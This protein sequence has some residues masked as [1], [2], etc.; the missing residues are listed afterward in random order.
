MKLKLLTLGALAAMA[1]PSFGAAITVFNFRGGATNFVLDGLT[2]DLLP[3]GSGSVAIGTFAA[4]PSND[5][6]VLDPGEVR[7]ILAGFTQFSNTASIGVG[8]VGGVYQTV[9]NG[10]IA[11]GSALAGKNVFTV[12]GN[13]SVLADSDQLLV[14][15]HASTFKADPDAT[16]DV[17]LGD[18][19]GGTLLVGTFGTVGTFGPISNPSFVLSAPIPEPSAA[20]LLL[21]GMMTLM[22]N[23]RVRK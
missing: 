11:A 7:E 2:G 1:V 21:G 16:D 9:L 18:G 20:I 3:G 19:V 5:D 4:D 14:Y 12:V 22:V 23:R 15:K 8:A 13:A 10:G 17:L 6:G